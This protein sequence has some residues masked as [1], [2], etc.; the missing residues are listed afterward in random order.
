MNTNPSRP[1]WL[2]L[3][4]LVGLFILVFFLE[5]RMPFS[6]TGH[7]CAEVG[8][9]VLLYGMV[10]WWLKANTARLIREAYQKSKSY[11]QPI[12][13]QLARPAAVVEEPDR[14]STR[15]RSLRRPALR[16]AGWS[17]LASLSALWAYLVDKVHQLF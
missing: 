2:I 7:T 12:G 6:K 17:I 1:N 10:S 3:Y 5:V 14:S 13:P 15:L 16:F 4:L 9:V 11:H 8:L